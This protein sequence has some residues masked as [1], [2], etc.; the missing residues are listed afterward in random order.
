MKIVCTIIT[1]VCWMFLCS[2]ATRCAPRGAVGSA[3][4]AEASFNEDAGAGGLWGDLLFVTLRLESG[5]ELLFNVDTGAP[6]TV[7]DRSLEPILGKRQGEKPIHYAWSDGTANTYR[8]PKLY[9]GNAQLRTG[10]LVWVDDLSGLHRP[11]NTLSSP[12]QGILGMDC[13]RHYA[14]QLDFDAGKMRFLESGHLKREALGMA[15]PLTIDHSGHVTVAGFFMGTKGV[16]A[17]IDTGCACDG[18]L[19]PKEFQLALQQQRA[20]WTNWF[21]YPTGFVRYTVCFQKLV[22]GGE[23]CTNIVID[24]APAMVANGRTYYLNAIGLPFL[25]RHLVTFDFPKRLMYLQPRAE[26]S[27]NYSKPTNAPKTNP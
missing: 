19:E 8:A 14:I 26:L 24:E 5:K 20:A 25:A 2:C 7:L 10:D 3:V 18:V 4:P 9:L 17:I 11:T 23:S 15:F 1:C 16:N 6:V 21:K 27:F 22:F 12:V 13:M